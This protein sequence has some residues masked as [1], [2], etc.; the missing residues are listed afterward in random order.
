MHAFQSAWALYRQEVVSLLQSETAPHEG[1]PSQINLLH[2][3][4]ITRVISYFPGLLKS[5]YKLMPFHNRE[6][7]FHAFKPISSKLS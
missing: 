6:Y 3:S 1:V 5:S 4:A 2:Q 7:V